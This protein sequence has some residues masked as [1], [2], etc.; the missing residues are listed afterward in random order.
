[1]YLSK[2][3]LLLLKFY[4]KYRSKEPTLPRLL[5]RQSL[6]FVVLVAACVGIWL[7]ATAPGGSREYGWGVIG[8]L[9]GIIFNRLNRAV[10]LWQRWPLMREIIN[11]QRVEE[12]V[13]Q[14]QNPVG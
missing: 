3:D 10:L 12:L 14:R 8:L 7:L 9:S 6:N 13:Q 2:Q 11:W 1:M 4:Q 5:M